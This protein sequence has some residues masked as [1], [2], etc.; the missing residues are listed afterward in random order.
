M[1]YDRCITPG[2]R[3]FAIQPTMLRAEKSFRALPEESSAVRHLCSVLNVR[4]AY[5]RAIALMVGQVPAWG[6]VDDILR[7]AALS[8][9]ALKL[10]CN[11]LLGTQASP[12]FE[13]RYGGSGQY[14]VPEYTFICGDQSERAMGELHTLA[15][16]AYAERLNHAKE[17]QRTATGIFFDIY[18]EG[19][20]RDLTYY[21][22]WEE[23]E[24]Q[25]ILKMVIGAGL[26]Q[27]EHDASV[28]C[29]GELGNLPS[30]PEVKELGR[31]LQRDEWREHYESN[32]EEFDE[33]DGIWHGHSN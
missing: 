24:P 5:A 2:A 6:D 16:R 32:W 22:F 23:M 8:P 17:L 27:S 25:R 31:K 14:N 19:R 21:G 30:L 13:V 4:L 9:E 15:E 18:W 1:G 33:V 7:Q 3:W 20:K 26:F 11:L 29:Q 12:K 28:A 10:G